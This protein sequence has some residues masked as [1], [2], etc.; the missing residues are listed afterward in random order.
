M[1]KDGQPEY[2]TWLLVELAPKGVVFYF[3]HEQ[4]KWS[5]ADHVMHVKAPEHEGG[6]YTWQ[7]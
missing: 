1:K 7:D 5:A 3:I 6:R 2:N 4:G